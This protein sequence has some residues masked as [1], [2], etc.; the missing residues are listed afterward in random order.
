[1]G[2]IERGERNLTIQ[3]LM[4]ITEGLRIS[5]AELLAGVEKEIET[6]KQSKQ[7]KK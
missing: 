4:T 5:M 2:S 7:K 3:T 1:M 6:P